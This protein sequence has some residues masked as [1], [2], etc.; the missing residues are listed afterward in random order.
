MRKSIL[1]LFA[2]LLPLVASA[3][4]VE[5]DGIWYNLVPK[6]K[7]A[8]VTS[9]DTKYSGSITI[10]ATVTHEGVDYNVTSIRS[11]A[12]QICR[13][14]TA[15]NIPSSVT[16]IASAAF[17]NCSSLTAINIP[18]NSQLTSIGESAFNGCSSLKSINIP[19]GVTSIGSYAFS[20]CSKLTAIT[21]PE[22]VTSIGYETF[23]NCSS[24]TAITI[25][26]D[27]KLTSIGESAFEDCSSLTDITIPEGVTSIEKN[28]FNGCSSL[29]AINIPEGVTSIEYET[30]FLCSSLTTVTIPENSQLTSIG[31]NAFRSCTSLT[32]ITIPEGVTGIGEDAFFYCS[33]LTAIT[34]PESVTSIGTTAFGFCSSLTSIIIPE[35]SQLTSIES[36]F[37]DCTSLTAINIPEGVTRI[38]GF[39]G[40]TSLTTIVLPKSVGD[41]RG[42][43]FAD[44]S[45]LSDVYCYAERVPSTEADAFNGSYIEYATLHVP[46]SAINDYKTTAPWSSF[47]KIIALGASITEITLSESSATLTEGEDLT[48]TMTTNPENADRNLISWSSS[49]PSVATVDN[50]GKVTA[51]A[52]GTATITVTA[53]DGSG[54]SASCKVEVV[55]AQQHSY[56]ITFLVDGEVYHQESLEYGS[57]IVAPEA[58][59]KEGYT[60][61]GWSNIPETMPANNVTITGTFTANKY[62]V[63]VTVDGKVVSSYTTEYGSAIV[64]PEPPFKEGYTFS[65]WSNVPETMPAGDVTITGSFTINK[66]VVTFKVG[67]EVIA[68]DSLEYNTAIIAP[69]VPE[70]EGHTFSGWGEVEETVPAHDVTYEGSFSVNS[71]LLTYMVDGEIYLQTTVE[72]G[73][74]IVAPEAPTKEGYTFGGWSEVPETMPAGDVTITGSFT[75]NKYV[76]TFKVGDEVIASDSLEY[77]TAIIAPEVPER[78]GHTFSGWGEVEETVPA[79]DVTYEGSFSVNSYLLTYMV[80]GE[81]Y[82]QTTVEYGSAI[83]APEAPTKEGYTFSGWSEVPETM[84]AGDVTVTGTFTAEEQPETEIIASGTCGDSLTWVLTEEY[85]LVIEGTGA[86]YDYSTNN[87]PWNDYR[88]SIQ[89]VSLSEEM[90]SIGDYAFSNCTKLA[91]IAIPESVTSIGY[92]AF[93]RCSKLATV[94]ITEE[95]QL[96]SIGYAAFES[97]SKLTDITIPCGVTSIGE[98]AFFSCRNLTSITCYATTP[99][100][101]DGIS[102]FYSVDKTIPVYV[103]DYTI[104]A[105]QSAKHWSEF[106]WFIGM[107]TGINNSEIKNQKSDIIYDFHGRRITD[108]EGLKGIYIVDGRKV[109][110]K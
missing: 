5:I 82:L 20:G 89:A 49:N 42:E 16:S 47:G 29:T 37:R 54:A 33:S 106:T 11:D 110:I 65:G 84:P 31:E 7:Q 3:E 108:T 26:E 94:T 105:Y 81:I 10:P 25:P 61:G 60:F 95:S 73:S 74:A 41:I 71:Y 13:S 91:A 8:E 75:I 52:P 40:C 68:S 109:V 30:F 79:H 66:Y 58:P 88:K 15:I 59:T 83:V 18:E 56:T 77:N 98:Y 67:D 27:S 44:C 32:A 92:R 101:I 23:Y 63:T 21:I 34:I 70:R 97:C 39:S 62:V 46:A 80:D 96:T 53:T 9:G 51:I 4:K 102:T 50:T 86:M 43:A 72:Y 99:P 22:R 57:S 1:L 90:T 104:A 14:L 100:T 17:Y 35:N 12:F 48:L 55:A 45:E 87:V 69:E 76:V 28:A 38:G 6:A 2:A 78:E 24:L 36:G 93:Y 107:E 64:V 103:L 19:E 85:E